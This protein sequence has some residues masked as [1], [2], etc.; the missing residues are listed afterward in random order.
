[1]TLRTEE[2]KSWLTHRDT[3][4]TVRSAQT[5]S[6]LRLE[7]PVHPERVLAAVGLRKALLWH[8]SVLLH[9]VDH[10]IPLGRIRIELPHSKI[11][12]GKG[13]NTPKAEG[14]EYC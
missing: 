1:M 2:T 8:H 5:P 11:S 9:Q 6:Y 12:V 7:E 10:H 4:S 14:K 13:V 3:E